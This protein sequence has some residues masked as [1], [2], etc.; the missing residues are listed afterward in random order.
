MSKTRNQR[1]RNRYELARKIA[2]AVWVMFIVSVLA[3][4]VC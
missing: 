2:V 4:K 3:G 1:K